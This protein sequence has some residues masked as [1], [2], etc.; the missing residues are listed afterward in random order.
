[1]SALQTEKATNTWTR[2]LQNAPS[3]FPT[4]QALVLGSSRMVEP[5][6]I[7]PPPAG[8]DEDVAPRRQSGGKYRSWR[9]GRISDHMTED[10]YT[11]YIPHTHKEAHIPHTPSENIHDTHTVDTCTAPTQLNVSPPP[12][13]LVVCTWSASIAHTRTHRWRIPSP[14]L[15]GHLPGTC[16]IPAPGTA[17]IWRKKWRGQDGAHTHTHIQKFTDCVIRSE[18]IYQED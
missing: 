1:M 9:S 18:D 12:L 2:L 3:G 10:Q 11:P 13:H 14:L 7:S 16:L 8:A 4:L 15:T 17:S 6:E 5:P